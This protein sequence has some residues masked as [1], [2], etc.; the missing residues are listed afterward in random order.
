[1]IVLD[2]HILIWDALAPE[3][4]SLPA[5][6]AIQ[7]ANAADGNLVADISLWEVAMLIDKGRVTV[8]TDSRSFLNL[9][10][11]ANRITVQCITPQIAT[12]ATQLAPTVNA[13]PADRLIVATALATQASLVTADRNLRKAMGNA[14]IW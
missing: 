5:T 14:A 7:A 3:R 10:L 9:I 8:T 12:L 2:T 6:S 4:L 13:D 11:A 1:M